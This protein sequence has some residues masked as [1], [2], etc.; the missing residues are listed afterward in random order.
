MRDDHE[1]LLDRL[2]YMAAGFPRNEITKTTIAVYAERLSTMPIDAVC[3]AIDALI[4]TAKWFPTIGE[5]K[6]EAAKQ[7]NGLSELAEEAWA[8]V[9]QEAGRVGMASNRPD[10]RIFYGG[11]FHDPD[12]PNFGSET[13][14]AAVHSIGWDVICLSDRPDIVRA[15]FIRTFN[16]IAERNTYERQTGAI[17]LDGGDGLAIEAGETK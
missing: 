9:R 5:I 13:A 16:A 4:D 14:A 6:A 1:R 7:S 15:Q 3:S 10:R 8:R 17:P 12:L 2:A 11:Q